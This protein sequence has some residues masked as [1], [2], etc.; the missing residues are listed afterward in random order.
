MYYCIFLIFINVVTVNLAIHV[1]RVMV[2][3]SPLITPL[4]AHMPSHSQMSWCTH[5]E[6]HVA[7]ESSKWVL[8]VS[9]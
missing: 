2:I 9:R 7:T 5:A 3:Q 6:I 4:P 8:N 1:R